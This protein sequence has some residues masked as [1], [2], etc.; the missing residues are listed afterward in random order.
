MDDTRIVTRFSAPMFSLVL[1]RGREVSESDH[2]P[3]FFLQCRWTM[4]VIILSTYSE[5]LSKRLFVESDEGLLC[6]SKDLLHYR[7]TS[8]LLIPFQVH[9]PFSDL[10]VFFPV[11][12]LSLV[13]VSILFRNINP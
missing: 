13:H 11:R 12:S 7:S 1:Y 5:I 8:T 9:F 4:Y 6:L 10:S 3:H 2:F